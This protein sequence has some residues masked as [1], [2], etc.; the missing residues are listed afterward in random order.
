M[1]GVT[2]TNAYETVYAVADSGAVVAELDRSNNTNSVQLATT[3]DSDNDG[4]SDAEELRYGTDPHNPDTDGDGLKDGQEVYQYST[5]PTIADGVRLMATMLP[6]I[7]AFELKIDD[8]FDRDV[9]VQVSSN[10][11][12]W[13]AITNF[14]ALPGPIYFAD[15]TT[16]RPP[17]RF[18]RVAIGQLLC[19]KT[20]MGLTNGNFTFKIENLSGRVIA[21][22]AST[23]LVDWETLT[24]FSEG[25]TRM[26]FN[27]P[28]ATN[29]S[30]RFYR[31][32]VP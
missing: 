7:D 2:F 25:Q 21:L 26:L 9:V 27:D 32:V 22:Q 31:A 16:P 28:A 10:L 20:P 14:T 17:I 3:L 29:Y 5:S 18:Y 12:N 13:A 23:N 6:D 24:N 8:V 15:P 4:L 19:L 30:Q 11:V 1:A